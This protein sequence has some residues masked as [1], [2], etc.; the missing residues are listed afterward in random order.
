LREVFSVEREEQLDKQGH[1]IRAECE[2]WC[3]TVL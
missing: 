3:L 2:Y 1:A